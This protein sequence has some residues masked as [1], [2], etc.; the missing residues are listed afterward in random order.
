MKTGNSLFGGSMRKQYFQSY[1]DYF[2]KFLEAY[3]A[4][5]VPVDAV[6]PQNEV[7]TDQDGKMPACLRGQEYEIEFVARHLGPQL[8]KN[9]LSTRIWILD[10]NYNLWGRAFAEL[11]DSGVRKYVDGIAWHGY[12]GEPAAMTRIQESFA[13]Q[14]MYWTEGGP[15]YTDPAYGTDW[16]KWKAQFADILRNRARCII[17]W[18]LA[19]DERGRPNIGPFQCGG[20]VTVNA[21]TREI[22]Y[23]GQYHALAHYSRAVRRGAKRFESTGEVKGVAHVGFSNPDGSS[24][25]VLTNAGADTRVRLALNGLA[26]EVSLAA[27]SVTTLTWR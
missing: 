10:H 14:H 5:G 7:D 20:L 27:D 6:T 9:K 22:T 2:I 25:L 17:G 8:E 16:A 12:V 11:E 24:A 26:A 3:A 21:G 15:E 1:A 18:N 19:L 23:S 13:D 4:E